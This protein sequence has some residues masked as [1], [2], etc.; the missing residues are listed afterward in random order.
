M[1]TK[2]KPI[3]YYLWVTFYQQEILNENA[4]DIETVWVAICDDVEHPVLG[5]VPV[6]STFVLVSEPHHDGFETKNTIYVRK[7]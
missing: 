3:A 2:D 7:D 5:C 6:V 1:K 4:D